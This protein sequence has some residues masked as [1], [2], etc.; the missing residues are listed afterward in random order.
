M[1]WRQLA[2]TMGQHAWLSRP[3]I[4]DSENAQTPAMSTRGASATMAWTRDT[5]A[6]T[7]G[8]IAAAMMRQYNPKRR[9]RNT[10]RTDIALSNL[11]LL[12]QGSDCVRY[13]LSFSAT[14]KIA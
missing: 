13:S 12:H 10:V 5:K 1:K 9:A 4:A 2:C 7:C 8:N 3:H 14:I 11:D 6:S